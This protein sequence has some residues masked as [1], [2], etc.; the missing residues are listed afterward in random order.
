MSAPDGAD[1][2]SSTRPSGQLL[3]SAPEYQD[4]PG[5]D[6]LA[7]ITGELEAAASVGELTSPVEAPDL[8]PSTDRIDWTALTPEAAAE[9]PL[10]RMLFGGAT[11]AEPTGPAL[12]WW[13]SYMELPPSED[14]AAVDRVLRIRRESNATFYLSGVSFLEHVSA[15][16]TE[17]SF[18]LALPISMLAVLGFQ[19]LLTRSF[20]TAV[21][22]WTTSLLPGLWVLG[23]FGHLNV[24]L[25]WWTMVVPLQV[26]ALSTSYAI[27]VLR[28]A[29]TGKSAEDKP[30]F[31]T[32]S[33]KARGVR[34]IVLRAGA[35]TLLGFATLL[36]S[37]QAE[38]RQTG[39]FISLGVA[40]SVAA[41]LLFFPALTNRPLPVSPLPRRLSIIIGAE[42]KGRLPWS[43]PVA[44]M[45]TVA[46]LLCTLA[47]LYG[48]TL[49]TPG[50]YLDTLFNRRSAAY[51]DLHHFARVHG[52]VEQLEIAVDTGE[53]YGYVDHRRYRAL[54]SLEERIR[55]IPGVERVIG[56]ALL[57]EHVF[58][59]LQG[60]RAPMVP[61]NDVDIGETLE[62]MR[63]RQNGLGITRLL[64]P[65]YREARFLVFFGS[66]GDTPRQ[67]RGTVR[68]I[69]DQVER[70]NRGDS[71]ASAEL[72]GDSYERRRLLD[73]TSR[74]FAL[75][76]LLFLPAVFV[77]LGLF[78]RSARTAAVAVVPI[79]AAA[80]VY[81]GLHG[82]F[83][84]PF[85]FA[86]VLGLAFV[87]GVSADDAI[88]V[89]R[90]GLS[91]GAHHR[92][93]IPRHAKAAVLQTTLL[94]TVG[95]F[96]L[97][98]GPFR[99]LQEM[100]MLVYGGLAT[101]TG[102]TLTV[103]PRLLFT[104]PHSAGSDYTVHGDNAPT[105]SPG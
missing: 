64:S 38:L 79:L 37:P 103:L 50:A 45:A 24:A 59:R 19:W 69:E 36:T 98:F 58:G 97:L 80:L 63:S 61:T 94:L 7:E 96:P 4:R 51:D 101:A 82:L 83:G 41:G 95:L 60:S 70:F 100:V 104:A 26:I 29:P 9:A 42:S 66:L 91:F 78:E 40:I 46:L 87:L 57:V 30:E 71:L 33:E 23:I 43:R 31:S 47:L 12:R 3:I 62:L 5:W 92:G 1:P 35:T 10:W 81:A 68:N 49:L 55:S 56:P 53:Q 75:S 44:A 72:T 48:L 21:L 22:L 105:D 16:E 73:R 99:A 34:P 11:I 25:N 13:L 15:E 54:R 76:L 2:E 27:H 14:H 84:I 74:R 52:A 6:A 102:V 17:R 39:L 8:S 28:Y 32:L 77:V 86:T 65:D 93:A 90:S 85:R 20:K 88:Y 89:I 18:L 67:R